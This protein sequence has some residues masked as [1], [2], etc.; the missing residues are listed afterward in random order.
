[1]SCSATCS[2]VPNRPKSPTRLSQQTT[3][4]RV[5]PGGKVIEEITKETIYETFTKVRKVT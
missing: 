2:T 5:V 4:E 3:R 1:M